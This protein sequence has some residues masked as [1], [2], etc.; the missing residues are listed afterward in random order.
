MGKYNR[1]VVVAL[2]CRSASSAVVVVAAGSV[3]RGH[4][5][6]T[7]SRRRLHLMTRRPCLHHRQRVVCWVLMAPTHAYT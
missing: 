3:E 7:Y 6:T 4:G 2:S 1:V 5:A